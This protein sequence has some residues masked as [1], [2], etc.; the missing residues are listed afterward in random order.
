MIRTY[1]PIR[2]TF[3]GKHNA[4]KSKAFIILLDRQQ[5][6]LG[7]LTLK[8]LAL[9]SS[10]SYQYLKSRLGVWHSWKYINRR[11]TTNGIKGK[12][13]FSYSI[14]ARGTKFV[15]ERIPPDVFNRYIAELKEYH[16]GR[17]EVRRKR[18]AAMLARLKL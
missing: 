7:G 6:G 18:M 5:K 1:R 3:N 8:Q 12:P 11:V 2:A 17:A 14:S 15:K 16:D 9:A 4:C 13:V 10:V